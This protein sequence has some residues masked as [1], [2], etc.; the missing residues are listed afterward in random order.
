MRSVSRPTVMIASAAMP[1]VRS[2]RCST[3]VPVGRS[4]PREHPGPATTAD[5]IADS[6]NS[7]DARID[8]WSNQLPS[9]SLNSMHSSAASSRC[10]ALGRG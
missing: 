5:T 2:G 3:P 10:K 6:G 4:T 1:T 9:A 8:R 7:G